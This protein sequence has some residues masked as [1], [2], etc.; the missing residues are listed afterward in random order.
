MH[1]WFM[2]KHRS[3]W[4]TV[5]RFFLFFIICCSL[6]FRVSFSTN[7]SAVSIRSCLEECILARFW[8][9]IQVIGCL[10]PTIHMKYNRIRLRIVHADYEY[11]HTHTQ[12]D[13]KKKKWGEKTT[14]KSLIFI[15]CSIYF[16]ML[17]LP[18]SSCLIPF[19]FSRV[20]SLAIELAYS[21]LAN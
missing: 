12:N 14:D 10:L 8:M 6:L 1:N 2:W 9:S 16:L 20:S 15:C 3:S 18:S 19:P 11:E 17:R 5:L 13:W 4:M 21:S 7:F